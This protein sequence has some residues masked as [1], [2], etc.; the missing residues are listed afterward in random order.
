MVLGADPGKIANGSG[1]QVEMPEPWGG[2]IDLDPGEV[3]VEPSADV[4]EHDVVL[5]SA[6]QPVFRECRAT[7]RQHIAIARGRALRRDAVG[8]LMISVIGQDTEQGLGAQQADV[9]VVVGPG[10]G[11]GEFP[12]GRGL[13]VFRHQA[14]IQGAG[15]RDGSSTC[16]AF[17][18]TLARSRLDLMVIT[19]SALIAMEV[20]ASPHAKVIC[21]GGDY[22][23]QSASFVGA[24]AEEACGR[25]CIDT[26][27]L[28]T[29]SFLAA[30]GTYESSTAT[31]RIK[32]LV[33]KRSSRVVLLVDGTKF[34]QRALCKVLDVGA[35]GLVIT[36]WQCPK[37]TLKVLRRAGCEVIVAAPARGR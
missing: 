22:D 5:G 13:Q 23:P 29:K 15:L 12:G 7:L 1:L 31:L 4:P 34:G 28:S 11:L 37:G 10:H 25:F 14:E 33:A 19:N 9:H 32:Q 3:L 27:F 30:E 17:A 6:A 16:I 2:F 26:T 36:D 24:L 8:L 35:I 18:R 20:G 21:V